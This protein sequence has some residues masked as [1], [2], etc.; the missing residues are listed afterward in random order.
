MCRTMD[1]LEEIAETM[2]EDLL[3]EINT[4]VV[5]KLRD[6]QRRRDTRAGYFFNLGES[7]WFLDKRQRTVWGT[8]TKINPKSIKVDVQFTG[9]RG[10]QETIH[11]TVAPSLVH[12]EGE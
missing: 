4:L 6:I 1:L 9:F 7:V 5:G 12:H 8:I 2:E 3:K 11:W 10:T